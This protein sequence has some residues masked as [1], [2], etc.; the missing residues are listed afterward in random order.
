[1]DQSLVLWEGYCL[2]PW[3]TPRGDTRITGMSHTDLTPLFGHLGPRVISLSDSA[4]TAWKHWACSNGFF[5]ISHLTDK[6]QQFL[7]GIS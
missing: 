3:H 7:G 5:A 6:H 2:G 1:M 4:G